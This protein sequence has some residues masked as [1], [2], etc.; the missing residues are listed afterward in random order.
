MLIWQLPF[1]IWDVLACYL[2][3]IELLKLASVGDKSILSYLKAKTRVFKL[4]W[5]RPNFLPLSKIFTSSKTF[6]DLKSL[7]LQVDFLGK[8][9]VGPIDLTLLPSTLTSLELHFT[10]SSL[11]LR[12]EGELDHILTN[13]EHLS[14]EDGRVYEPHERPISF[15]NLSRL[16]TLNLEGYGIAYSSPTVPIEEIQNLPA[17]LEHFSSYYEFEEPKIEDYDKQEYFFPCPLLEYLA[18]SLPDLPH[19]KLAL[20]KLPSSLSFLSL[21][22]GNIDD[23]QI[24][25]QTAFPD[26]HCLYLPNKPYT[27]DIWTKIP[28]SISM[29]NFNLPFAK[30]EELDP[31]VVAA[32]DR[33]QV[34]YLDV[35]ID[36]SLAI[37]FRNA[38]NISCTVTDSNQTYYW[39]PKLTSIHLSTLMPLPN[40]D[41]SVFPDGLFSL[42]MSGHIQI[43]AAHIALL[44]PTLQFISGSFADR[45][46]YEAIASH[47]TK[48]KTIFDMSYTTMDN[49]PLP[50]NLT[51]LF[52]SW[53]SQAL[54]AWDALKNASKLTTLT[55]RSLPVPPSFTRCLG[56]ALNA[57]TLKLTAQ[58]TNEDV[59]AW[60][61]NPKEIDITADFF[62]LRAGCKLPKSITC[63]R[64]SPL[65]FPAP[66]QYEDMLPP[67]LSLLQAHIS[68]TSA[69]ERLVVKSLLK[70]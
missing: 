66:H 68:L 19:V 58:L 46:T 64:M 16:K 12:G 6:G 53:N 28:P 59:Q 32:I 35:E 33:S 30:I 51:Y 47:L 67:Y 20:H 42:N 27:W 52:V 49:V 69:Y 43:Q 1:D 8:R 18:L 54:P 29:V 40:L 2:E 44:P 65:T 62:P 34:D 4:K 9:I 41:F 3:S 22:A 57:W 24:D 50:P 17:T 55:M 26:L 70:K 63:L 25:W 56:A 37:R 60:R 36:A 31:A 39:P 38:S 10:G 61:Y 7:I 14:L 23:A 48:L 11:L 15:K 13:L 5:N 21:S 45:H